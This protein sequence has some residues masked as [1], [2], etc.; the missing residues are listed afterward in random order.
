[1]SGTKTLSSL[2]GDPDANVTDIVQVCADN[3]I[4]GLSCSAVFKSATDADLVFLN[5]IQSG[6]A[7]NY[8]LGV[9]AFVPRLGGRFATVDADGDNEFGGPPDSPDYGILSWFYADSGRKTIPTVIQNVCNAIENVYNDLVAA[10]AIGYT[11]PKNGKGKLAYEWE[12]SLGKHKITVEIGPFILPEITRKKSGNWLVNKT[13][14]RLSNYCEGTSGCQYPENTNQTT[15]DYSTQYR[16]WV[17]IT[18]EDPAG[19]QYSSTKKNILGLW[20]PY[21]TGGGTLKIV[22]E[23]VAYY[24]YDK[25]GIKARRVQ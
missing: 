9:S 18:R 19:T 22:R 20:N 5:A 7:N 13:C 12:D 23:S 8:A 16:T 17:R 1:L 2:Y 25:V 21:D 14:Q 24:S 11:R 3:A 10:D 15:L 4:D 6:G